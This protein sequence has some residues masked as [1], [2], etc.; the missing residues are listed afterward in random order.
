MLSLDATQQSILA[1]DSKTFSWLFEVT[2]TAPAT[3]YWSTKAKTFDGQAYTFAILPDSFNG[4]TLNRARSEMGLQAPSELSFEVSN[5]GHS[6]TASDFNDASVLVKLVISDGTDE[7]IIAQWLFAA[8]TVVPSIYQKIKFECEDFVQK[9][10]KGS[11]PNTPYV[12]DLFPSTDVRSDDKLCVPV[13]FGTA[14]VPLRSVYIDEAISVTA[15]T[16]SAVATT[17]GANCKI[18]DSANGLG[19]FEAKRYATISGFTEGANNDS[20]FV[21]SAAAGEIELPI[22]AGIVDEAAGDSVTIKQGSRYYVLGTT[23]GGLTYTITK[24]RTPREW[25]KKSE[26]ASGSYAMTQSTRIDG[27]GNSWRVFQSIIAD[28]DNDNTAD[29]PGLWRSGDRFL[30]MPTK[31]T[32]SDTV[33]MTNPADVIEFVLEDMGVPSAKIDTGVGS[34]FEAAG[35]T[36][37]GWGLTFNGAF[38]Y[39]Q[40]RTRVLAT[41]LNMCHA[42]L[43]ITDKIELHVLSKTSQK[44]FTGADVI[45]MGEQG[46]G[47]FTYRPLSIEEVSDCGYIA[48]QQDDEPQDQF[49]QNIVAPAGTKNEP[50]GE[51]LEV[52]FVQ[53][54]QDVQRIGLL[55]YERRLNQIAE[56]SSTVKG[57]CLALQ[58]DDA[59]TINKDNYGG[60]YAALIDRMHIN[61]DI[62]INITCVRFSASLS[63]WGDL[64]PTA[65]TVAEDDTYQV[66]EPVIGGPLSDQ[67]VGR[68]AYEVWGRPDLIVGPHANAGQF[69]SIQEAINALAFSRHLGIFILNGVYSHTSPNHLIDRDIRFRGES[70]AGVEIRNPAG[71]NAFI[72]HNLDAVFEFADLKFASQNTSS[73]AAMIKV[74]GDNANGTDNLSTLILDR[75]LFELANYTSGTPYETGVY[76]YNGDG[77][78]IV[79][80]GCE[81]DSGYAGVYTFAVDTAQV[82]D[83]IFRD[84]SIYAIRGGQIVS[85]N[86]IPD[87]GGGTAIIAGGLISDNEISGNCN[88]IATGGNNTRV[89]GNL[90]NLSG[91]ATRYIGIQWAGGMADGQLVQNNIKITATAAN[92]GCSGILLNA[93]TDGHIANNVIKVNNTGTLDAN[94]YNYGIECDKSVAA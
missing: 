70:A 61:P 39:R 74:Y 55:Y 15:S 91:A 48:W 19:D 38:W 73:F 36:F 50:S 43:V 66:W 5:E 21:E 33:S 85:R 69:T 13:P 78:L 56:T 79:R 17:G 20:F 10:L 80:N 7:E 94:T 89:H 11:W 32:R 64:S 42:T 35:T 71:M 41:L 90:L 12:Q 37:S 65:I 86:L 83:C 44:T 88:G 54:S 29:A 76:A 63:D 24:V 6:L 16:I 59:V 67:D 52:P 57:T 62:S 27:D 25:G 49:L 30:D 81:F 3:Y 18:Q 53:D 92:L 23:D 28:G 47:T 14:Y 31:F 87:W 72:G 4:I 40:D 34:S 8:K 1:S 93:V 22:G 45:R 75:V 26:W 2:T 9:Y 46:E 84:Q 51:N 60:N 68:S 82:L 58:P 77:T